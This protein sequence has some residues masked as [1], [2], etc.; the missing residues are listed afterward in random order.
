V[1]DLGVKAAGK[2]RQ[3]NGVKMAWPH[4]GQAHLLAGGHGAEEDL[5]QRALRPLDSP[6]KLVGKA[7]PRGAR[8]GGEKKKQSPFG[9]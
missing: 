7:S 5:G 3:R 1:F 2:T 4:Q 9:E 6:K 8:G